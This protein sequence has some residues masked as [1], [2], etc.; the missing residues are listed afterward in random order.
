MLRILQRGEAW[1]LR[2][3]RTEPPSNRSV[4]IASPLYS[5]L[6]RVR[7]RRLIHRPTCS[8][9]IPPRVLPGTIPVILCQLPEESDGAKS[10][11]RRATRLKPH[12]L[13]PLIFVVAI[14]VF[15]LIFLLRIRDECDG[16]HEPGTALRR[17]GRRSSSSDPT[18]LR[19]RAPPTPDR[20]SSPRRPRP[21]PILRGTTVA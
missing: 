15:L 1:D 16:N 21:P 19:V 6:R 9:S 4:L 10:S 17:H 12:P 3:R 13:H 7:R 5:I 8:A 11:S 2:P 14:V 20:P 18:A